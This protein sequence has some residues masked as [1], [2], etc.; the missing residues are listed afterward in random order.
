[1]GEHGDDGDSDD[2][3][4]PLDPTDYAPAGDS[5]EYPDDDADDGSADDAPDSDEDDGDVNRPAAG[6]SLSA[7]GDDDADDAPASPSSRVSTNNPGSNAPAGVGSPTPAGGGGGGGAFPD[8]DGE[9]APDD[10]EQPLTAHIEE[11]THRFL[12]VA[13]VMGIV[14][15]LA[16]LWSDHMINFLWYSFLGPDN[17][18]CPGPGCPV[19]WRPHLYHPLSL[20]L[21]RLK[22]G[23]L[24]G[25]VAGLPVA[26]YEIYRF[27]RPGLYPHER[28]YY[29][30]AVPT[31]LVLAVSGVA[32]AYYVVLPSLFIY[33][34]SYST[35]AAE[36]AFGLSETF[37]LMV[38]MLG[39]FAVIFQ[40]PLLVMLAIMMGVTTRRWLEQRRIY[41]WSG[42]A[43]V[44]FLFSPD[45]TGMA[46]LLVA[47]TMIALFEGTLLLLRWTERSVALFSAETLANNRQYAWGLAVFIGYVVS[48]LPVPSG[49]FGQLPP[50]VTQTLTDYGYLGLTPAI[51]AAAIIALFEF[52]GWIA[53]RVGAGQGMRTGLRVRLAFM[54][55]RAPVWFLALVVGYMGSPRPELLDIFRDVAQPPLIAAGVTVGLILAYEGLRLLLSYVRPE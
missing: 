51:I 2:E 14:A 35:Q 15:A 27:M 6:E 31:S 33:F 13:L 25:F 10:Q 3:V 22:M 37:N 34:S 5:P 44:A 1:M 48:S 50:V 23:A 29:L 20:F 53:R 36:L 26:V 12:Y 41:F 32:F 17:G 24:V 55:V 38:M 54:R 11:M 45:P 39:F 7:A 21:A 19:E 8:F 28:R 52:L 30:A 42:F 4:P 16:L 46:P 49:Y 18:T 9:M 43:G 47:V 40:I